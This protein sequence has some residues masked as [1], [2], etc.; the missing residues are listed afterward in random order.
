MEMFVRAGVDVSPDLNIWR[1]IEPQ[2][3]RG[4]T[5]RTALFAGERR[6]TGPDII[7]VMRV[8]EERFRQEEGR[9]NEL[10][11]VL[12]D[13]DHGAT[14]V[15]GLAA[16]TQGLDATERPAGAGAVL[17]QAAKDFS[18]ATGGASGTL[19][20]SLFREIGVHSDLEV[21]ADSFGRGLCAAT[22]R[23]MRVGKA[24]P[25]DKTMVDALVPAEAAVKSQEPRGDIACESPARLLPRPQR[26]GAAQTNS[27]GGSARS[28]PLCRRRR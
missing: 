26:D 24:A 28:R 22:E 3:D 16:V 25:G 13:G 18:A 27:H 7:A 9:L 6:V 14:M 5:G 2:S 8:L 21:D 12:G 4:R 17:T 15:R 10:D 11:S 23:V 20:S 19:F 1:P